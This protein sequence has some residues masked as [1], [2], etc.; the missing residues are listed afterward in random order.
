MTRQDGVE[1]SVAEPGRLQLFERAI[2][3]FLGIKC[4][5]GTLP[6]SWRHWQ[7]TPIIT[8]SILQL[9]GDI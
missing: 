9:R 5:A 3:E 6:W 2:L 8:I 1:D 7:L 4:D